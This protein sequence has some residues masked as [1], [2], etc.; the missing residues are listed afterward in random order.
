[1]SDSVPLEPFRQ[2]FQRSGLTAGQV[3]VRMGYVRAREKR[4]DEYGDA[5]RI[6]RLLNVVRQ[7]NTVKNG[8]HYG[9]TFKHDDMIRYDVACRLAKAL[10]VDPVDMGI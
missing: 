9:G 8:K 1:M 5:T 10:G 7:S 6:L 2:A 4:G 3:A